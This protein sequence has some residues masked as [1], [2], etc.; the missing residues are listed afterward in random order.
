MSFKIYGEHY[1]AS[2]VSL[3]GSCSRAVDIRGSSLSEVK[4][5]CKYLG[6]QQPFNIVTKCQGYRRREAVGEMSNDQA[7]ELGAAIHKLPSGQVQFSSSRFRQPVRLEKFLTQ[8]GE[9]DE[10]ENGLVNIRIRRRRRNPTKSKVD[11]VVQ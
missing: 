10:D 2:S 11:P 3:C 8:T 6:G 4:R 5:L 7:Y 9:E 1:S